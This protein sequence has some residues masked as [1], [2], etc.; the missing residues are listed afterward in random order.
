MNSDAEPKPRKLV[1]VGETTELTQ[2]QFSPD[3]HWIAY[4][5][6]ESGRS[7]VFLTAFPEPAERIKVSASGGSRPRW[8]RDGSELYFV[9]TGD[10]MIAT[11]VRLGSSAPVGASRPLFSL[12]PA[13]WQDYDV[14]AD[15]QRF[16]VVVNMPAP[17]A[18]AL[19]VTVNWFSLLKR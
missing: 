13:G 1:S 16:L 4:C 3:G 8:K 12:G 7:E 19:A 18:N 17:D 14:T 9:S 5:A 6:P 11:A 15:G 10:E 2:A